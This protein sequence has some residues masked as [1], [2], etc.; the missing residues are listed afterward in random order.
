MQQT[1]TCLQAI[2]I[3]SIYASTKIVELSGSGVPGFREDPFPDFDRGNA[4]VLI[5]SAMKW[6]HRRYSPGKPPITV[7]PFSPL[8][9][10]AVLTQLGLAQ[11]PCGHC[12]E[13]SESCGR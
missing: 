9:H 11:L 5:K 6:M 12:R 4:S 10:P 7:R 2:A 8:P 1:V 3:A 13:M